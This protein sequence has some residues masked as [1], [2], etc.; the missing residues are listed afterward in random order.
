M[1]HQFKAKK[2]FNQIVDQYENDNQ[3]EEKV[4]KELF[5]NRQTAKQIWKDYGTKKYP[6]PLPELPPPIQKVH[7]KRYCTHG[8]MQTPQIWD[9][10]LEIGNI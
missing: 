2:A 7:P 8:F 5:M 6:E 3:K 10:L 4:E 1:D 9:D